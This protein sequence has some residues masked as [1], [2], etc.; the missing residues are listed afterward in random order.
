VLIFRLQIVMHY[1]E[2]LE[3]V[4]SSTIRNDSSLRVRRLVADMRYDLPE[5][6][7]LV[8]VASGDLVHRIL[9]TP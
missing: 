8:A 1:F 2:C 6:K 7:V 4:L 9:V 3:N 5:R